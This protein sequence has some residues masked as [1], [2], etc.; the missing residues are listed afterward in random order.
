MALH[1]CPC[2]TC[3]H[4]LAVSAGPSPFTLSSCV[5]R[6]GHLFISLLVVV[7]FSHSS[8]SM[9]CLLLLF[10]P[11]SGSCAIANTQKRHTHNRMA[12]QFS[13]PCAK[14]HTTQQRANCFYRPLSLPHTHAL[15]YAIRLQ[16]HAAMAAS[17]SSH[18]KW[19][20]ILEASKG[21]ASYPHKKGSPGDP[22]I[23]FIC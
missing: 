11:I 3:S 2:T 15:S 5:S 4:H 20:H 18:S 21:N 10:Y 17:L 13:H 7:P 9:A 8:S 19:R 14:L 22:L 12:K 16:P 23:F 1:V 6:K